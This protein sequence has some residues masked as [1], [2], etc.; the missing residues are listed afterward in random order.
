MSTITFISASEAAEIAGVSTETIRQLCKAG[1]LKYQKKC[2]LYY[3]CKEDVNRYADS[4]TKVYSIKKD[5]DKYTEKIKKDRESLLIAHE[6]LTAHLEAIKLTPSNI[7]HVQDLLYSILRHY[8]DNNIEEFTEREVEILFMI[9]RGESIPEIGEKYNLTKERIRQVWKNILNKLETT[10]NLIEVQKEE[11]TSLKKRIQHLE[12]T[13]NNNL[14]CIVPQEILD[15]LDLLLEPI[16]AQDF[17]TR[18][19]H[20]LSKAHINTVW[21]LVMFDPKKLRYSLT[22]IRFKVF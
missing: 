19:K 8:A 9:L 7:D 4:V 11:I 17:S 21:D 15:N 2:Q 16:S 3:P 18:T 1:T 13:I 10:R 12:N 20:G 14:Y 22:Y 5:I 6:E